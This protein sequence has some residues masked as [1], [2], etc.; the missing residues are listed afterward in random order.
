MG[1]YMYFGILQIASLELYT[2]NSEI[3]NFK[4]KVK[5]RQISSTQM[6][7]W[8]SVQYLTYSLH[9]TIPGMGYVTNTQKVQ[10]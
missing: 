7:G 4:L 5:L 3:N 8:H 10:S 1:M 9:A 6:F 2:I